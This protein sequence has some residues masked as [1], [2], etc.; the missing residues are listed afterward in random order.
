MRS[1]P[2]ITLTLLCAL[3]AP[4]AV[5]VQTT[6][7]DFAAGT[8][9]DNL[10]ASATGGGAVEFVSRFDYNADGWIDLVCTDD[11]L[12]LVRLYFGS[13]TGYD[14]SRCISYP[15]PG[16]GGVAGAD[17]DGD[18]WP[19][20]IHSGWSAGAV[21]IYRGGPAGPSPDDTTWLDVTGRA[22]AVS[23]QDLDRDNWLDIV[24]GNTSQSLE[25]FWGSPAGHSSGNLTRIPLDG[26]IGHNIEIADYDR[27]GWPDIACVPWTRNLNPVVYWGPNR[28]P[29]E[30]VWL[31]V[32]DSNPHGVTAADFNSDGW[33]DL[34]FSHYQRSTAAFVYYG[35]PDGFSPDRREEINP[36]LCYGGS[37]AVDW[38]GDSLL[39]ILFFSGNYSRD[40][41]LLPVVYFNGPDSLPRF[42]D[43]RRQSVGDSAFNAS[44]GLVADLNRDGA[45]DVYIDSYNPDEPSIVLWGPGWT[46]R[47]TLPSVKSHH[48]TAAEIGNRYDRRFREDYLSA[49]FDAGARQVWL[50]AGWDD[51]TPA[52]TGF[53]FALRTGDTPDPDSTWSG[54][55]PLANG[56]TIPDTLDSRFLQ[57][58]GAFSYENP[59]VLPRLDEVRI[60]HEAWPV[61][62]VGAF[63]ILAPVGTVDSG[64]VH[65]PAALV[66][67]FGNRDE[68]FPVH[69]RIAPGYAESLA[70]NLPAG[71]DTTVVFP[72]WTAL[73]VGAFATLC[74]TALDIDEN[75]AND[76][77]A[78]TVRVPAP[79][80]PDVGPTRIV[81]PAGAADSGS[82][83]TPLVEVTNFGPFAVAFPVTLRIGGDY[84]ETV[85]ESLAIGQVDTV[86]FPDWTA[87]RVDTVALLA[88][89]SL[90][91][92]GD[93]GNDTLAADF[94]VTRPPGPDVG[95][96]RIVA[97]AGAADSGSVITPLVEVTNFGPF[98]ASFPVT[99]RIDGDYDETV[100]ESLAIG[101]VDTVAFPAW[102]V[103][104]VGTIPLVAFTSLAVDDDRTND[105]ITAGFEG[106]RP[107]PP[108]V[109]ATAI[110]APLG[111]PDS[112]A[113][114]TPRVVVRNFGPYRSGF[115][116]TL[117]IAGGYLA[118]R[119]DT[120]EVGAADTLDFPAWTAGPVGPLALVAWTALD[121]D[122]DRANDTCRA[123][124][125]VLPY[126]VR[127]VGATV[128]LGPAGALAARDTVT[129]RAVIRNF[130]NR[131]E[132]Y[133]DVRFRIGAGYDRVQVINEELAPGA[134]RELAFPDWVAVAGRH[135]VVCSTAL[136]IDERP[137]ND[138]ALAWVD[139]LQPYRLEVD[140]DTSGRLG[141]GASGTW[142]FRARLTSDTALTVL[143]A[144]VP[145]PAGWTAELLDVTGARPLGDT[146]GLLQ[147]YVDYEFN[148]RVT[149]P[150]PD[151]AGI[152]DSLPVLFPVAGRC[153]GAE[154]L[155]D[156]AR[157]RVL[158]LPE[159]AVHN[160]PNP[161]RSTTRFIFGL[162][163]DGTVS[164]RIYTRAGELVR[165][166]LD[167]RPFAAGVRTADWDAKND[168][169]RPVGS[170][171]YTWVFTFTG[172]G[173][174]TALVKKLVVIRDQP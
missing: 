15:A 172:P 131:P 155:A 58:R 123:A 24:V 127:D 19:E 108:D 140:P 59:C 10:Y 129:P 147:P 105:T 47:D 145:A 38:N 117:D 144:P 165:R 2:V 39:D 170:G 30:T 114:I 3:A 11:T 111:T 60:E 44:G 89:T 31:P 130:G 88:F 62:D 8:P 166:L 153:A 43:S 79:P 84:A 36:G 57:Y 121:R 158:L 149:T 97:P 17:L 13:A 45:L 77:V 99:L 83:I 125:E 104:R 134:T 103:D 151:L 138:S 146:L 120:L 139:V 162:P 6:G 133:F 32:N 148:L 49:V 23:I 81:A 141:V 78:D 128:I 159:L 135:A 42:S 122:G 74:F 66:R 40:T 73:E 112:G 26:S 157:L 51:S 98:A 143:I 100:A 106:T 87:D 33:L 152:T 110:L 16:G 160:F 53:A 82:V 56:D 28:T 163:D 5:W 113:V 76:T 171:T 94:I 167:E 115:P 75:R 173:G 109:G 1:G 9:S 54:W 20:L 124:L 168:A 68:S 164:L 161:L 71:A 48:G 119:F 150:G 12:G 132:R 63:A 67:N 92:D 80:R 91:E 86:A 156:T 126:P 21:V 37:A 22:E 46:A 102:T 41:W 101:Q 55:L 95:P 65:A 27:D 118:T 90:E 18:G 29:R 52:G 93:R 116:T 169:G 107:P 35:G 142:R 96:T 61:R 34:V 70:V 154:A 64:S 136:A 4:A 137:D 72:D 50:R 85:A 174:T 25:I 14:S 7:P 69:F